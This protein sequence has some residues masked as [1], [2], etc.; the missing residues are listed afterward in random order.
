VFPRKPYTLTLPS[1]ARLQLG[2]RTLVMAILN[3]TPDSFA[4]GGAHFDVARAVD[5]GERMVDEG[6]D[7]VDVGGESTRPGAEPVPADEER[8]RVLPVIEKLATRVKAPISIDTY[9]ADVADAAFDAGAAIVND[10]SG[11]V[12]EPALGTVA[13]GRGMPIVLMHTRGRSADMYRQAV[14]RDP[15]AEVVDEIGQR[16]AFAVSCGMERG[17]IVIDPGLGFAKQAAH[18][19]AT[20]AH[21]DRLAATLDLPI[22]VGASRKSFL[23]DA[24][25]DVPPAEREWGSAAAVAAAV[26]LGA[27]IVRVHGVRAMVDVVKVADRIRSVRELA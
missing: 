10:V 3:I 21:L 6:A 22:L 7:I 1:G 18:S 9:K 14:Y 8:R 26:L 4:D 17:Q 23:K 20:L 5:A 13:A 2:E 25:G 27:H 24:I 11:L 16:V 12:Y 15:V 19:Y